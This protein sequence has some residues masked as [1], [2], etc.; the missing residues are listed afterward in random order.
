MYIGTKITAHRIVQTK[1]ANAQDEYLLLKEVRKLIKGLKENNDSL[2][3]SLFNL[4]FTKENRY[5]SF[6]SIL[7]QWRNGR[8][9]K[10]IKIQKLSIL[11][12][13]G[14][15]T[16]WVTFDNREQKFLFQSWIKTKTGWKILWLSK[17]LPQTFAYGQNN[18]DEIKQI[19]SLTLKQLITQQ[20]IKR[21]IK[22]NPIPETIII[23]SP[24]GA[25]KLYFRLPN[26]VVREWTADEIKKSYF[27]TGAL[28]FL[29][30]ATIRILGDIATCYID[31]KPLYRQI[32][33]LTRTRGLQL[34]FVK[35]NNQWVFDSYG[36]KW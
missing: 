9:I 7:S 27:K 28:F 21:I 11:G 18:S 5:D 36:S 29:E 20:D 19:K 13:G 6:A 24:K 2:V 16:S 30:F 17:L 31:I 35:E 1:K 15:I 33:H 3:Y 25:P 14:N 10:R 23:A 12:R 34:Y 26:Y 4:T 8:K 32:P 22:E